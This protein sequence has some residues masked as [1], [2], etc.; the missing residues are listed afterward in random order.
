VVTQQLPERDG[1]F[2]YAV[3]NP[4]EPYDRVAIESELSAC[5]GAVASGGDAGV[6]GLVDRSARPPS[7]RA[8]REGGEDASLRVEHLGNEP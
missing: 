7:P 4:T 1:A 8:S 5:A 2:E 3:M 6:G